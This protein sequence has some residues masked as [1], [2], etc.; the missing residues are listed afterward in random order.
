MIID[1]HVEFGIFRISSVPES[2]PIP[3]PSQASAAGSKLHALD[4]SIDLISRRDVEDMQN[5]GF[6]AT[7][8][9]TDRHLIPV[10]RRDI[11]IDRL[12]ALPTTCITNTAGIYNHI[13]RGEVDF[14]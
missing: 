3:P 13:Q 14:F 6:G 8:R 7:A 4:G 12:A 11:P 1:P 5:P 9:K 2:L 10:W